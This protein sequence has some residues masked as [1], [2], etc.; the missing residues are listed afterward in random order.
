MNRELTH[1]FYPL[2]ISGMAARQVSHPSGTADFAIIEVEPRHRL[3]WSISVDPSCGRSSKQVYLTS[4]N[5]M[6]PTDQPRNWNLYIYHSSWSSSSDKRCDNRTRII[7]PPRSQ[8]ISL[9][10]LLS[11][12]RLFMWQMHVSASDFWLTRNSISQSPWKAFA[13]TTPALRQIG[14]MSK[15][16]QREY[17][18]CVKLV[19]SLSESQFF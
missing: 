14:G 2:L 4:Y 13:R 9:F 1:L 12:P 18:I 7:W 16:L 11:L 8:S 17:L 15:V 3:Q 6:N 19:A 10:Q 5:I